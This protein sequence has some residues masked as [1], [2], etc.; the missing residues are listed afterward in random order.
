MC[1][2]SAAV[3]DIFVSYRTADSAYGAAACYELLAARF[4]PDRVFRDCVSMLPGQIYPNEL[5][6]ALEEARVLVA[7]IGPDWLARDTEGSRFIDRQSD[8]VRREVARGLSRG[9]LVVPVLLDDVDLP[10][11]ED[12]PTDIR[13]LTRRQVARVNSRSLGPDVR[14]LA[15]QIVRLLPE[16]DHR[17]S[18]SAR[19]ASTQAVAN[20]PG[21]R[22]GGRT[23]AIL[24]FASMLA[25]TICASLVGFVTANVLAPVMVALGVTAIGLTASVVDW[26]VRRP[27]LV[28][29]PSGLT[30]APGWDGTLVPRP[31]VQ[32]EVVRLL[33]EPD[34]V[35]PV[36]LTTALRGAGGFGKTVLAAEVCRDPQVRARFRGGVLWV[37]VGERPKDAELAEMING[38]CQTL[39]IAGEESPPLDNLHQAGQ[40]LGRLLGKRGPSL[41][42]VDDVWSAKDLQ[43]FLYGGAD[44]R[45]LVT[46]RMVTALPDGARQVRVDELTFDQALALL[47][48][49]LPRLAGSVAY[50]LIRLTGRWTLLVALV[51]RAI[52]EAVSDG[53]DA[54]MAAERIV[55]ALR[56]DGPAVLDLGDERQR[57]H[58]VGATIEVSLS[59]LSD[60]DRERFV[61]LGIFPEDTWIPED[62]LG[63][64]WGAGEAQ[65]LCWQLARM[66]LV[67]GR[68]PGNV[69]AIRLHDVVRSYLH[70]KRDPTLIHEQLVRG[71]IA[72]V[73]ACVDDDG[74]PEGLSQR[75]WL[76]PSDADYLWRWLP[77]HLKGANRHQELASL[78]CDLR[79]IAAKTKLLGPLAIETDIAAAATPLAGTIRRVIAQ[80]AHLLGPTDPP[81]AVVSI[82]LSR[83]QAVPELERLVEVFPASAPRL[84]NYWPIPDIPDPALR[85]VMTGHTDYVTGC[86]WSP[87][88]SL[89]ATASR[90]RTVRVWDVRAGA[91][92]IELAGHADAVTGCAWS[93][94]GSLL[95]TASRDRTVRVW[96]VPS[97]AQRTELSGHA[98]PVNACA[99]S[100][101]GTLL[102]SAGD[103][104]TIRLWTVAD[105][106]Q[107]TEI[108]GHTGWVSE[109]VWSPD[110]TLLASCG[111]DGSVRLWEVAHGARWAELS[112]SVGWVNGCAW[113]PDGGFLASA[114]DGATVRIW[115]VASGRQ[116]IAFIGHSGWVSGCAWSP[117]G[118]LLASAGYD[119]AVRVWEVTRGA[120][121]GALVDHFGSVHGCAWSPNG[122][123]LATC[124]D[125]Q[126]I[127]VWDVADGSV[128]TRFI[129][130]GG[131][132]RECAWSPDGSLLTS[133]SDDGTVRVWNVD[134][135]VQESSL[136]G[137]TSWV[138]GCAWS[139]DGTLIASA[140]DQTV[141]VWDV[142]TGTQHL[143]LTGHTGWVNGCAWSPDGTLIASASEDRSVRVWNTA[144]GT[145][146]TEFTAHAGPVRACAWST[147][148]SLL[149]SVGDRTVRVWDW[150]KGL[151]TT[152][153]KVDANISR[154]AWSPSGSAE[155]LL[156]VVGEGGVY[157]FSY[158]PVA[159]S[160]SIPEAS[161]RA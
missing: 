31:E 27:R 133:A 142:A 71:A 22:S 40:E 9:I 64:L 2:G 91:Q 61:Q 125:D 148:G 73:E 153:M 102:A 67:A 68:Q 92:R 46:T 97:G 42:V 104:G 69:P 13:T 70:G 3:I 158:C 93:Q 14:R 43:P 65:R 33:L 52:N 18:P 39:R 50:E 115:E 154:C 136:A 117:D 44:C 101:D 99:W 75:W 150:S 113:S 53:V 20:T 49:R 60:T 62:L 30:T 149:A 155:P 131:P 25:A 160:A 135:G 94:D 106:T 5:V 87:D 141:R 17:A 123:L 78:V 130:H 1:H 59:F 143:A 77:Y 152:L 114:D 145:P 157:I 86:A 89:L 36:A 4:D 28:D 146:R 108:P 127:R 147:D 100:P 128:R 98:G 118:V 137:H 140:G 66:S 103:D 139:P 95:A 134:R 48:R 7:V 85:R 83:L 23:S 88:G 76:L 11:A 72:L 21:R 124:G 112:G 122:A 156:A 35:A 19:I 26:A 90:D 105:G 80:S 15:D 51:N 129:G 151:C 34:W 74:L 84:S 12:L 47:T 161:D 56:R 16:L 45:R 54:D 6:D 121:S 38:L 126:T 8:W 79:W 58:L 111:E 120:R 110:G 29:I 116:E 63:L 132:V 107:R 82:L 81:E 55:A 41:L 24:L 32:A 37:T 57:E 96:E 10:S 109:C 119:A 144:D 138:Y 159:Q